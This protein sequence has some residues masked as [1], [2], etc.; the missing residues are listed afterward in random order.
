[1]NLDAKFLKYKYYSINTN[2]YV[3]MKFINECL[4]N[5]LS[6]LKFNIVY[7]HILNIFGLKNN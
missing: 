2:Y 7:V 5:I 1:M 3:S 4:Y 6:K